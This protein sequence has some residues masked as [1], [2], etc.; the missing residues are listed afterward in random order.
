MAT[1]A[2]AS[3]ARNLY[4]VKY[5]GQSP[6]ATVCMLNGYPAPLVLDCG[7]AL[8]DVERQLP[9]ELRRR[10]RQ[11]KKL[12]AQQSTA[13]DTPRELRRRRRQQTKLK[14]QQSTA[15]DTPKTWHEELVASPPTSHC[16]MMPP[17]RKLTV[18]EQ[19]CANGRGSFPAGTGIPT[20]Q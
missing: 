1:T 8:H 5:K 18:V 10:R 9:R 4:A 14:A 15:H 20:G 17:F 13:H 2:R 19:H 3:R 16:L 11:Q 12:K 6:R 7:L